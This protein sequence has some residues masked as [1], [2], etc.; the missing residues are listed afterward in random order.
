MAGVFILGIV[1]V[2]TLAAVVETYITPLL[3]ALV[4]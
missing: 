2:M 3:L 1:P 4:M